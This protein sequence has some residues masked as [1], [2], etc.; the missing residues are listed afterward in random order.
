ME[1]VNR[2]ER[3]N[4]SV[5]PRRAK[6]DRKEAVSSLST[7]IWMREM[8]EHAASVVMAHSNIAPNPI[9]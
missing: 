8:G 7:R 1:R 4:Q 9:S 2:F 3:Q 6:L 5:R